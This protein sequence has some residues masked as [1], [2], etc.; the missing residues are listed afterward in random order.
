MAAKRIPEIDQLFVQLQTFRE[1][2]NFYKIIKSVAALYNFSAYNAALIHLQKPGA[3]FAATATKWEKK[4]N[5]YIKPNARPLII[6][7]P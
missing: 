4:F 2:N 7:K 5:R 3:I 6:L 1:T